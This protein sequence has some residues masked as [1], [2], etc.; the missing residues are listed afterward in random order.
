MNLL[1]VAKEHKYWQMCF[2]ISVTT[3]SLKL[4]KL[5]HKKVKKDTRMLL[6]MIIRG[7]EK[8]NKKFNTQV[9]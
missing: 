3:G 4:K 6:N 5:I 8:A 7:C 1:G 2:N 9:I